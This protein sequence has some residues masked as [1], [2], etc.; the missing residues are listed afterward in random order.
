MY[1]S[2]PGVP[3]VHLFLTQT[4]CFIPLGFVGIGQKGI[5]LITLKYL[6]GNAVFGIIL[7]I[8]NELGFL[9]TLIRFIY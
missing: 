6:G 7:K 8:V 1:L 5:L 3:A 9:K 4:Y 2:P